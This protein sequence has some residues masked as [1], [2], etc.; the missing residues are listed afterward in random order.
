MGKLIDLTGRKFGRLT[1]TGRDGTQNGKYVHW[2]CS[3]NCGEKTSV[4][5]A[6]LR[7][8]NIKSCSCL[9]LDNK[10][11]HGMLGTPTYKSWVRMKQRCTNER[12]LGY[13][14]YGGRG[15]AICEEWHKFE[16]FFKDMGKRPKGFTIERISNDRGYSKENC[17]WAT[18]K[19][20]LNNTRRQHWF[21]AY[22]ENTGEWDEHNSQTL[23][24]EEY[25]INPRRIS[26]CL[27]GQRESVQ[28]WMFER[29]NV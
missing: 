3:C 4:R 29:V 8:G 13:K 20:Q 19:K 9:A 6:H 18:M 24:G 26:E 21:F 27:L 25:G 10:T 15:I 28:G 22:N 17:E 16:N 12:N 1:V 11:I 23:F 5:S 7:Y 2:I 14:N